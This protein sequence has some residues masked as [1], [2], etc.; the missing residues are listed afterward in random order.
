MNQTNRHLQKKGK[1]VNQ[2]NRQLQ[3]KGN[4]VINQTNRQ[5]QKNRQFQDVQMGQERIVKQENASLITNLLCCK[6]LDNNKHIVCYY[7]RPMV[8]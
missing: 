4:S 5:I 7:T 1:T 8:Q 3:K 2:T 6:K